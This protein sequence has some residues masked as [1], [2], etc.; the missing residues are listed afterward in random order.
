[1]EFHAFRQGR[2]RNSIFIPVYIYNMLALVLD[3]RVFSDVP[4]KALLISRRNVQESG[5]LT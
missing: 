4:R 3:E 1:M 5:A 2:L